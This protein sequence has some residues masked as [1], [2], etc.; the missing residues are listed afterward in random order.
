M[1]TST[2]RPACSKAFTIIESLVV[3]VILTIFAIVVIALVIHE[4]KPAQT[5]DET[6]TSTNNVSADP[7]PPAAPED[8]TE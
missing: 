2:R 8:E 1:L 6:S 5:V 7:L 3:L 4:K